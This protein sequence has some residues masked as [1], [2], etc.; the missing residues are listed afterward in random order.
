MVWSLL[1][2]DSTLYVVGAFAMAGNT[3]ANNIASFNFHD[4]NWNTV[5]YDILFQNMNLFRIGYSYYN[6]TL[7]TFG[8]T[9]V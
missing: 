8:K 9:A 1:A 2:V 3:P 5:G 4:M 7:V 6:D